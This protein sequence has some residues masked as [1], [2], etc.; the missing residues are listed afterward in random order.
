MKR[1][2][3][4]GRRF[5]KNAMMLKFLKDFEYTPGEQAFID[6]MV[7]NGRAVA[8]AFQVAQQEIGVTR[9]KHGKEI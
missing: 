1:M 3:L 2:I 8:S 6:Q 7:F 4:V 5:G 9:M